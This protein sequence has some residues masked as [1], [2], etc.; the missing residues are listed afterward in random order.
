[1]AK[2]PLVVQ[3]EGQVAAL[4]AEVARW[5]YDAEVNPNIWDR[6]PYY[7]GLQNARQRLTSAQIQLQH[8]RDSLGPSA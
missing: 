1:M 2:H 7:N 4:E 5:H 6:T 3:L 8:A